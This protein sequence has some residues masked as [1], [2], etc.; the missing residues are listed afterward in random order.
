MVG[1]VVALTI[2]ILF[3][4]LAIRFHSYKVEL[5]LEFM[6]LLEQHDPAHH[7]CT[8]GSP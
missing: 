4:W 2:I 5:L 7:L 8:V 1:L 3:D 6:D